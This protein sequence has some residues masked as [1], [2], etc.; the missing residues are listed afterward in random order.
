MTG[1][2]PDPYR[3]RPTM[4][5]FPVPTVEERTEPDLIRLSVVDA[6]TRYATENRPDLDV[7]ASA[8]PV[9]MGGAVGQFIR[10]IAAELEDFYLN[11]GPGGPGSGATAVPD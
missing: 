5:G 1:P 4:R 9:E 8:T 3:R 11:G 2:T 6:A 10:G 7:P